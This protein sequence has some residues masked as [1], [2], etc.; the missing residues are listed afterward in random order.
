MRG[1]LLRAQLSCPAATPESSPGNQPEAAQVE[2]RGPQGLRWWA[3]L[4]TEFICLGPVWK[5]GSQ[6]LAWDGG[7]G[8]AGAGRPPEDSG[9]EIKQVRVLLEGLGGKGWRFLK[10]AW[11]PFRLVWVDLSSGDWI[12]ARAP[13]GLKPLFWSKSSKGV[14]FA[15]DIPSLLDLMPECPQPDWQRIPEYLVFQHV[16]AGNTLYQG[17]R[18]LL[19]GEVILGNLRSD[20]TSSQSL[21]P[22]WLGSH[23]EETSSDA[24]E[25]KE[26]LWKA[27]KKSLVREPQ[28][29]R[30][31][32]LSGGVDSALLAWGLRELEASTSLRC[33]TVVCPGYRYDEGPFARTV[34]RDLELPWEPIEL[35]PSL[36]ANAWGE[37]V[38]SLGLPLT[39]TNQLVWWIL[40]KAASS[41]GL[42]RIFSGEGADG[43]F[44]GGLYE[45][46]KEALLMAGNEFEKTSQVVVNCRT[47]TLN[48][49]LLVGRV[50]DQ[51]LDLG[52]RRELWAHC[53]RSLPK[54]HPMEKAVLYHVRTVGQ[55]L[56]TRADLT[57]TIHGVNLELP[58]LDECFLLWSKSLG[59]ETRNPS[60]LNKAPL[61]S[62]CAQRFGSELAYRKKIGFPFPIRTWIRDSV[63]KRLENYR[64]MLLEAHT[65]SRPIY[66]RVN[67]EK[68]VRARLNG[69]LRPADWLLWSLINLELWLRWLEQR[70]ANQRS[71]DYP[72]SISP[73]SPGVP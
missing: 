38:E 30:G 5:I 44:T 48:E 28:S 62:L 59:W 53:I 64:E 71:V 37:A 67:L 55:R 60:G 51:P 24:T 35:T 61:K 10:G 43:W 15:Q 52:P 42:K 57:S 33:F 23:R 17:V 69:T 40:S 9:E 18:E 29:P 11:G 7:L 68:E 21:W 58:F 49:P 13:Q 12:L 16:A 36:F 3:W 34:A 20:K 56:L 41:S 8:T 27:I 2:T 6:L 47:H 39:S 22:N 19:P 46:E 65:M 50:L 32:F 31:L 26:I 63:E 54:E 1:M 14:F 45:E 25:L 70:S 4:A 72:P 66:S 73:A